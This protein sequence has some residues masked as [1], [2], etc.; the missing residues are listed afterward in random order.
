MGL[1]DWTFGV[2]GVIV[3]S[4]LTVGA[5]GSQGTETLG[6]IIS[7]GVGCCSISDIGGTT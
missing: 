3:L 6:I 4:G 5:V 1:I 2:A 7:G